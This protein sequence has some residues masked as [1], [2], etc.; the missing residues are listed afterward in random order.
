MLGH[1]QAAKNAYS[2]CVTNLSADKSRVR[3]AGFVDIQTLSSREFY[4]DNKA[5]QTQ[6]KLL[7]ITAKA[8]K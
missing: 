8:Y 1:R 6:E 5:K 4:I 3:T 7:S 2:K